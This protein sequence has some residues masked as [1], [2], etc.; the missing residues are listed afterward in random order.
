MVNACTCY[1]L[2]RAVPAQYPI[3]LMEVRHALRAASLRCNARE[4]AGADRP[5]W[6]L[7]RTQVEGPWLSPGRLLDAAP[8]REEQPTGVHVGLG[9]PGGAHEEERRVAGRSRPR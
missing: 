8:G 2:L 6:Q 9:K 4:A 5:L 7:H 3:T 1:A